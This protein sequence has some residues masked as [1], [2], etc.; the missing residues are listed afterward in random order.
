M[1]DFR[2]SKFI[3]LLYEDM[4]NEF[5]S[6]IETEKE[7]W[8]QYKTERIADI[9]KLLHTDV[10]ENHYETELSFTLLER[11]KQE[12][13]GVYVEKYQINRIKNLSLCVYVLCPEIK[14]GKAILFL[15]GHD[16]QGARGAFSSQ[17]QDKKELGMVMASMGY[18]VMIPE[19]FGFGEAIRE[20]AA[21]GIAPCTSCALLA[22][23]LLN[24]GMSL[25]GIRVF[26]A[27]KTLD[28][29]ENAF[30]IH[31]FGAYGISGGGHVC[32]Y[33]AVLDERIETVMISG[34]PNL[35]KY[36]IL[37]TDH[38]ICN[39]V[40]G[41]LSVGESY[42]ITALA[43]PKKLL[44][45]NGRRDPIFPIQGSMEAFQY[46]DALYKKL[47]VPEVYTHIL[48]D[49]GHENSVQDVCKWLQDNY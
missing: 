5:L 8:E 22:P 42:E 18:L 33:A 37:A 39:Y 13:E 45:I 11:K 12:E 35:Y 20:D 38:C 15:N 21:E 41:Q 23:Q 44:T 3:D 17:N 24:N 29:A 34:Y 28:F 1:S 43:A 32:N 30:S 49:G 4:R 36:S 16:Q 27:M 6:P 9:K 46:L 47:E 31:K 7:H 25:V 19:L 48:F 10:L 14:N 26:E 40:P 2:V